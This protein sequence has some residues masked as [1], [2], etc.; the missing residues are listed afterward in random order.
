M[1][2]RDEIAIVG[3]AARLPGAG[4]ID[5][6]WDVLRGNRCTVSSITPDRFPT[7]AF[8]HPG[9]E[10][11]GRSY[12]FAAGVIDD[13]WGF[14]A[15]AF[16]MSPREAA[17]VDPQ[18][19]HLLEVTYDAL[20]HAGIPPST[21]AGTDVGVYIGAS[22]VD[23][24]VRFVFD[25]AVA[26]MHMMT[27]NSA[28]IMAN[29]ISYNLDLHGPSLA[30]DTACS[31]SM[32]A[33]DLAAEAIRSGA[34]DT[35]IVGGVN[36]LL[37][38][39]SYVGFSR[40]SM[41]SPT[42]LC[43]PFDSAAD[44]YVRSEGAIVVVLRSMAAAR[45]ARNRIDAVIVGS[46]VNQ[47]GRTTGLALPSPESQR[48][49]LERVYSD[50]SVD[51]SDL[52]FVEAHGTGTPVGDPIE[53]DALGKG[54][55]QKRAQVLRIGSVKSNVGHLEPVSGLAGLL[56]TIGALNHGVVPATL[57]QN[58]PSPYIPFNDLNL[59]VLGANWQLPERRGTI[60]AGVNSFGFGGTNAHVIVRAGEAVVR[61]MPRVGDQPPPLL[62]SAHSGNALHALAKSYVEHWPTDKRAVNEFISAS[63]HLR[64]KHPHRLIARGSGDEIRSQLERFATGE[65][66]K[67]AALLTDV[68]IGN[69][70]PV[71]FVFAG[72]GSQWAGMGRQAWHGNSSFRSALGD[73]DARF[74][75]LQDW[76]IVDLLFAEDLADKLRL[77]RFS[78]PLLLAVQVATVRALEDF[79][80]TPAAIVGHSVGEVA[81]AWAAGLLSL[82]QA[83]GVVIARSRHQEA[84]HRSGSMAALMLS[85]RE[86]QGFLEKLGANQVEIAAVN[87][88]RSVTVSGPTA[89]IERVVESAT[90]ARISATAL[91]LDYPFH[92][93]LV[94]PVRGPL[95]HDLGGLKSLPL[96]RQFISSVYGDFVSDQQLD[97]EYWWRNVR[98]PVRF[99][100]AIDLLVEKGLRLFVEI[101]PKPLLSSYIRDGLRQ[102]GVRGAI[103]ETLTTG[104]QAQTS[105]PI[106][107]AACR[108]CLAGGALDTQRLFGLP[109]A[110]PIHLPLYPWQHTQFKIQPSAAASTVFA[111]SRHPLLGLRP[112][113]DCAEWFG[114][115]DPLLFPWI[116]DHRLGI[117]PTF[118]ATGFIEVMLAAAREFYAVDAVELSE[119]NI[120]QPLAFEGRASYDTS[121]RLSPETGVAEFYSRRR[122]LE[123]DWSLHARG[124]VRRSPVSSRVATVPDEPG[125]SMIIPRP[126]VYERARDL[127]FEYGPQFQ[128]CKYVV[129]PTRKC[130]VAVLDA[131]SPETMEG[132]VSDF[133]GF[134]A[135]FHALFAA[136]DAGVADQPMTRMLPVSFGCVRLFVPGAIATRGVARIRRQSA[137]SIVADMEL[138]NARDEVILTA[139]NARL[140][141]VP[142]AGAVDPDSLKHNVTVWSDQLA[143]APSSLALA[144]RLEASDETMAH[145]AQ[146]A[147]ALLL[148]EA[149]CLRSAWNVLS[150]AAETD[151]AAADAE[152]DDGPEDL[153]PGSGWKPFL[154]A[155]LW[156]HLAARGLAT[157]DGNGH[158]NANT[159]NLPDVPSI[160]GSILLRH[161]TMAGE[162][163]GLSRIE[164]LLGPLLDGREDT[165][166]FLT[167]GYRRELRESS[168]HVAFLRQSVL[169]EVERSLAQCDGRQLIRLLM[170][171]SAHAAVAGRLCV[172]HPNAEIIVTDQQADAIDQAR[173]TVGDDTGRLRFVAWEA[174]KDLPAG[175]VDLVFAV[176]ALADLIAR[177][178]A[179]A[180]V[181][182][183]LR[184]GA[185]LIAAEL[186]SSPFWDTVRGIDESWWTRSAN[187]DFPVSP[188]LGQVEWA[189]ELRAAGFGDVSAGPIAHS[190]HVGLL[191]RGVAHSDDA[192]LVRPSTQAPIF[193]WQGSA[194]ADDSALHRLK[195]RLEHHQ[196]LRANDTGAGDIIWSIDAGAATSVEGLADL[197][198][199]LSAFCRQ[200]VAAPARLSIVMDFGNKEPE[201]SA[202]ERPVWCSLGSAMRVVRNEYSGLDIRCIGI[203][204]AATPALLDAI[205]Q[206]LLAPT[207]EREVFYDGER[208]LVFRV[209][210]DEAPR[211]SHER[212]DNTALVLTSTRV[213]HRTDLTWAS[214]ERAEPGDEEIE[215]EVAATGLNFRDVMWH[216]HVLPEEAL[217]DG[218]V[219]TNLG[220]ECAGKV[221]RVGAKVQGLR[222]GDR[223]AAFASGA[224]ASHVVVPAFAVMRLPDDLPLEDA[225]T[226]PVAFLTAYYSLVHLAR[227]GRDQTVLI[228]GAAGGVGLAAIQIALHCGA[229]V[230]ATA[231][232]EEKRALLRNIGADL[233]C[234]SRSLSFADE[235]MAHTDRKGV[236]V[237]LNSLSGEAM[238][239]SLDCVKPFGRFIELGK[240]DFYSNTQIGLKPLRRN[241]SYLAVD[242]DQLV[243]DRKQ[244][245]QRLFSR[246]ERLLARKQLVPLPHRIFEGERVTD[247]FRLM[248]RAGH[249][250]KLLVKPAA[251]QSNR[252]SGRFPVA[253]D[254]LHIVIGGTSGFGLATAK[255]LATRGARHLVLASRSGVLSDDDAGSL[256]ELR[257]QGVEI[258]VA[259][260]DVTDQ[261]GLG[262]FV[263]GRAAHRRIAGIV[264]AA[265]VLEDRLIDGLDREAIETV[266]R[267]KVAGALHLEQVARDL[268]LDYL[269]LFSS[270]TTLFGNPGQF[271]YVAANA[272]MEGVARR[273]RKRGIPALSVAWG[274][275]E[276]VGYLS[277]NIAANSQ[278]KKRFASSLVA[279]HT[280][281]DCLDGAF[282]VDGRQIRD[283]CAIAR[284]DWTAARRELVALRSPTFTR[285]GQREGSRSSRE[286]TATLDELRSMSREDAADALLDIMVEEI[287]R[288]L[289]LPP[290]EIDRH[291][292]LADIG[293]DSLMMLELRTMVEDTLQLEL[294]MISLASGITPADVAK[295]LAALL[296]EDAPKHGVPSTIVSL[297]TSHFAVDAVASTAE[298]REAAIKAVLSHAK[299][300]EGPL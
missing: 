218:Y 127:G 260:V 156:S 84:V 251:R 197:L 145:E 118:P 86:A 57:H 7:A 15:T 300:V 189:D 34:I 120:V 241:V 48:A 196:R 299:R 103:V 271:N 172:S 219:G 67:S 16:G 269:L 107:M 6:F 116:A 26:D 206:E 213:G 288:V 169:A 166:P 142:A 190:A 80:V 52:A 71:A 233:V 23:H 163:A 228:H 289:R 154:R 266:L 85:E 68:A 160:V 292:P 155:A 291:R 252:V 2:K 286:G 179:V 229:K 237:V 175:S 60:L 182:R 58:S 198:T 27:G 200:L 164:E 88:W 110:V 245:A 295:R 3:Y 212:Q 221:V 217:E 119:L 187:A 173:I 96:K 100:T 74:A 17:Q 211:A 273:M 262:R 33:L 47:D 168:R 298:E 225:T 121:L 232:T 209:E 32:V 1:T 293:M 95:L 49:L 40:A 55:G 171:G 115:I 139:D 242:I 114:T 112:R 254:G 161:P 152:H 8:L 264:H 65:N 29:R 255:W 167:G 130:G 210:R 272:F 43:R 87:S 77:A 223:V 151:I 146:L 185:P 51:P 105:D 193:G 56:K 243:G 248:Q 124:I 11:L 205:E 199:D 4:N 90:R 158:A 294:P 285:V 257:D 297:S 144:A 224:F 50:F 12:T 153:D 188:L 70:L 53:A 159:C 108:I 147:E 137:T 21:L 183:L 81:A 69:N 30:I 46:G 259:S 280:A 44:G 5:A 174:L 25:P 20:A 184:P 72:N 283:F 125:G 63:A 42:G 113:T 99:S 240:R 284:I 41:L 208:R 258:E 102:A 277:R 265:M 78:Q 268:A 287:G 231:G 281:L 267:P 128:R 192:L 234:N 101:S 109:P 204:G 45:K 226:V 36:L 215:I 135:M 162:A 13:P 131:A 75:K 239:R 201:L 97:A 92:S 140:L 129:F 66:E 143:F 186:G 76:S 61:A 275:I 235:V 282:D 117:V 14:D 134:D 165:V 141:H 122:M 133:T 62:L 178:E 249:I 93:A 278:L 296:Q 227:L 37:S 214:A 18:Q 195:A 123:A 250:G 253:G 279:S 79:G 82:D 136:E 207:T 126:R 220:M 194:G 261:E 274:G 22:S 191:L 177:M 244:E 270:A 176:D 148:L 247:A 24:A 104:E 94:D 98:H 54:L 202:L 35:A 64:D 10:Q 222:E 89:E 111:G 181:L 246:V 19:R 170:I 9:H 230:I 28:S 38:P 132:Y 216:L 106:E 256:E 39:F 83:I 157:A 203:A 138:F 73:L 238:I 31:S 290:K 263:R 91:D 149:G 276:D 59:E 236:D 150:K 180:P